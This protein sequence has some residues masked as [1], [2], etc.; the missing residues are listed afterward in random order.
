MALFIIMVLFPMKQQW[1]TYR[2]VNTQVLVREADLSQARCYIHLRWP[3]SHIHGSFHNQFIAFWLFQ[4]S[5]FFHNHSL[6]SKIHIGWSIDCTVILTKEPKSY[7]LIRKRAMN[8]KNA[9]NIWTR[10]L[11]IHHGSFHING[12]DYGKSHECS[13]DCTYSVYTQT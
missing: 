12:S 1:D 7:E 10:F 11:F 13:I 6:S 8:V 3:C 2:P 9:M 5:L 4:Y